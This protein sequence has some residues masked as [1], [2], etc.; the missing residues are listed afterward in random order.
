MNYVKIQTMG[1]FTGITETC[2]GLQETE[3][4]GAMICTVMGGLYR[5]QRC[6]APPVLVRSCS[7]V[8]FWQ[9]QLLLLLGYK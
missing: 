3:G 4:G 1:N 5:L 7:A 8:S 6:T 2:H 9:Y